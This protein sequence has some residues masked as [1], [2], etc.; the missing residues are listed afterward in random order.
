[1]EEYSEL[2]KRK[3]QLYFGANY[4][5]ARGK[6][7]PQVVTLLAEFE[8]DR[9]LLVSIA[10]AA[11]ADKWRTIF[12]E[13][14]RLISIG[15]N[16]KEVVAKVS[17]MESDPEIVNFICNIWYNVQSLYAESEIESPTNIWEGI[18]WTLICS[19]G[20]VAMFYFNS[21]LFSKIVW[22]FGLIAALITWLYGLRQKK[23]TKEIKKILEEDYSKF[24]G[25]I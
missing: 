25:L 7:H 23:L 19:M 10:D 16:Y 20:L 15:N 18:Q 11:M 9:E 21:S 2:T 12:N 13:T 5:Y 17:P 14:Q 6:S 8:D 1:M 22:S 4:L 3:I 24:G